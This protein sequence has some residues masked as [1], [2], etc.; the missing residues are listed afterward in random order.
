MY[1]DCRIKTVSEP[2][3]GKQEF[4]NEGNTETTEVIDGDLLMFEIRWQ[5]FQ[6]QHY[7]KQ[8]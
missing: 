8:Q 4:R 5:G 2:I 6:E 3:L 7:L 1:I